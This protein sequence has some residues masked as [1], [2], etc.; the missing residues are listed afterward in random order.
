MVIRGPSG[1]GKSEVLRAV[2]NQISRE[3]SEIVLFHT[4]QSPAHSLSGVIDDLGTQLMSS[5][6]LPLIDTHR[7]A[8]TI[9]NTA[10]DSTWSIAAT[11]LLNVVDRFLPG[12]QT[13][14]KTLADQVSRELADV[15]PSAMIERMRQTMPQDLLVGFI[16]ILV[17]L[18]EAGIAGT[19]VID[20]AE[21][22]SETVREALLGIAVQ[23]PR[24]WSTL[25]A[26]ND[27]IPEGIQFLENVWPRL[28]YAQATRIILNPLDVNALESWCL[29][30][31]NSV[32]SLLELESIL[33]NCQGRPLLLREWVSGA[34]TEAEL[35]DI[36]RRLGP[37]YQRRLAALSDEAR[38]L[39]RALALLPAQTT[40]SLSLITLLCESQS[41]R[42][43]FAIVEELL[44]S[45]FL[46]ADAES[47]SYRFVHDITKRQ[48]LTVMPRAVIRELADMVLVALRSLDS[49]PT[50]NQLLYTVAKLDYQ[51]GHYT[52]FLEHALPAANNL[53]SAGSYATALELY[54]DCISLDTQQLSTSAEL[55]ARLGMTAVLYATGYYTEGLQLVSQA[56]SWAVA[57]RARGLLAQGR[58]LLRLSR[59]P[60]SQERLKAAQRQYQELG[61]LEG[62]IQCE[63]E[64]VTVLRDMGQYAVA[65]EKARRLVAQAELHK[66][67]LEVLCSCYRALAR[68][69]AFVGPLDEA[70]KDGEYAL[71]LA[72]QT[73][74]PSNVGNAHLAIGEAYRLAGRPE[75]AIAYYKLAA[76]T[77][78]A[79][80]NRDSYLWSALALS[81][82]YFLLD[83]MSDAQNVLIP[84]RDIVRVVPARYPLVYLHWK[85]SEL[86]ISHRLGVDIA[87]K[88]DGVIDDYE[89]LGVQW[90]RE[91][92]TQLT[93]DGLI[94]PK[95]FG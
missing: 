50:D 91:Y 66:V 33:S 77:A 8:R 35:G 62:V 39:V 21:A 74:S 42:K 86:A 6:L 64:E 75:E 85:L 52:E 60:E 61:N 73:S 38:S 82:S 58:L 94:S 2:R 63:K 53:L 17:A 12:S 90:P 36:W 26:V 7:L 72:Q 41:P 10:K 23:A 32:P 1:I 22:A 4:I 15:A 44:S 48:V 68:S 87:G 5:Q 71:S 88:L 37:Y 55:E 9:V 93:T 11:T 84:V 69:R 24:H 92:V 67:S 46:E 30:E 13:I 18:N 65:V 20:Q 31:R 70:L 3:A 80:G 56:E 14:A 51:A 49:E 81:D 43:A 29:A 79:L 78:L 28:A 25:L 45:Q 76:E 59:F 40:F 89:R 19:I 54:E 34:S 16:N 47:D 57:F 83:R 95:P 27:E